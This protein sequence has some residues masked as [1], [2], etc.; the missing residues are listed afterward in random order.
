[1]PTQLKTVFLYSGQGSHYYQMGRELFEQRGA[2]FRHAVEL[3]GLM[4][5]YLGMSIVEI[6]YDTQRRISDVF[7]QTILTHPAIFLIECALSRALQEEGVEP[8][9][10]LTSSMGAFAALTVAGS[11]TLEQAVQAVITQAILLDNLCVAGDMLALPG[12]EPQRAHTLAGDINCELA[13]INQWSPCVLAMG[14]VQREAV[15]TALRRQGVVFQRLAVSRAFHSRWIEAAEAPFL[16][17]LG[18]VGMVRPRLPLVC[19]AEGKILHALTDTWLWDVIRQ[20]I[21]LDDTVR[22]LCRDARWRLIDVGPSGTLATSLKY[23]LPHL[24]DD[25]QIQRVLSPFGG[26]VSRYH[27]LVSMPSSAH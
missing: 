20:P 19:C 1:M 12:T 8:D 5:E 9:Y 4:H 27:Q 18:S 10:L 6:L 21:R 11:L 25:P 23:G 17:F 26:A 2:F 16:A 22:T 15:E 14:R 7:D 24:G 13:A 3:D